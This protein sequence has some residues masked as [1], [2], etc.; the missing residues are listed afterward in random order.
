M[1]YTTWHKQQQL[2]GNYSTDL[3]KGDLQTAITI[4]K[5]T[6]CS[7]DTDETSPLQQCLLNGRVNSLMNVL[8]DEYS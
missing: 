1:F 4:L 2:L 7:Y 5:H 6:V 3:R 8:A